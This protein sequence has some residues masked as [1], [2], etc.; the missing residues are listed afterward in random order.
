MFSQTW[1]SNLPRRFGDRFYAV[2]QSARLQKG[3]KQYILGNN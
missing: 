2:F 1:K 3:K